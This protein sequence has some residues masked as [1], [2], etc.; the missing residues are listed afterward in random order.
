M[1]RD[2]DRIVVQSE[3]YDCE[4]HNLYQNGCDFSVD[5]YRKALQELSDQ[6]QAI[7][8]N[9][10]HGKRLVMTRHGK[11]AVILIENTADPSV[12]IGGAKFSGISHFLV[13]VP[14]S[15]LQLND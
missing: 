10:Q 15:Q 5:D 11:D 6:G 7:I 14:L 1:Y 3:E 9:Q 8:V 2:G 4:E 13:R 12:P